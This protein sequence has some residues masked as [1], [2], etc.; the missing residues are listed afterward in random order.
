MY[1]AYFLS[2][3]LIV[4]ARALARQLNPE[5]F[6]THE[7][8]EAMAASA[9][10]ANHRNG[11]AQGQLN[12]SQQ[13]GEENKHQMRRFFEALNAGEMDDV[14]R[15]LSPNIVFL[16]PLQER[17]EGSKARESGSPCC[18]TRSLISRSPSSLWRLMR[19]KWWFIKASPAHIKGS[20]AAS[21]PQVG[22]LQSS[23]PIWFGS[24]MASTSSSGTI[25]TYWG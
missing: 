14:F 1:Q 4:G 25:L 23:R 8:V 11:S 10:R 3:A 9:E 6:Y 5:R 22:V 12:A 19:I 13:P 15:L 20:F 16:A 17:Q 18:T 2:T 21:P 7:M 24:Q